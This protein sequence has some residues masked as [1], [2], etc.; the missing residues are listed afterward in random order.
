MHTYKC[1]TSQSS[2]K[3][4]KKE[5]KKVFIPYFLI[6]NPI[7]YKENWRGDYNNKISETGKPMG[8]C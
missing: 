3:I 8:K 6:S 2:T 7:K 4:T 1:T 5:K